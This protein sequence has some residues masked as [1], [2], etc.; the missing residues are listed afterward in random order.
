ME[1]IVIAGGDN[2]SV[3]LSVMDVLENETR[4]RK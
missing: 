2:D 3:V 1:I 4:S